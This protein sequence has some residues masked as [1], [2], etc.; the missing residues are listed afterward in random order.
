MALATITTANGRLYFDLPQFKNLSDSQEAY[1][2]DKT[3]QNEL[4]YFNA[5]RI[6]LDFVISYANTTIGTNALSDKD[7][8]DELF[9]SKTETNKNVYA[10]LSAMKVYAEFLVQTFTQSPIMKNA[11]DIVFMMLTDCEQ[12]IQYS[13]YKLNGITSYGHY[14]SRNYE[15]TRDIWWAVNQLF[16]LPQ[17]VLEKYINVRDVQPLT[18]FLIRQFIE[19]NINNAVGVDWIEKN[20]KPAHGQISPTINFFCD[21]SLHNGFNIQQPLDKDCLLEIYKWTNAYIHTGVLPSYYLTFFA[22]TYISKLILPAKNHV[23]IYTGRSSLSLLHGDIRIS[24]YNTMK[25]AYEQHVNPNGKYI[26]HWLPEDQVG[27]YIL[28]L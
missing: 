22:W 15:S 10:H 24:N 17:S 6:F 7:I 27:A 12:L 8:A 11:D 1:R 3:P 14:F 2:K 13:E 21:T 5:F 23:Q 28:S 20:G 25:K 19:T 4:Q 9:V 18:I 26:I 16:A